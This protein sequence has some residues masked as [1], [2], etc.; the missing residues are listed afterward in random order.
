M[1][2]PF[3]SAGGR[4][5]AFGQEVFV[6]LE[7]SDV[8]PASSKKHVSYSFQGRVAAMVQSNELFY[9]AVPFT[10]RS[11]SCKAMAICQFTALYSYHCPL[12]IWL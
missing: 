2:C 10:I 1:A 12:N 3:Y 8:F 6:L 5:G 7:Y 4:R 11:T 9:G